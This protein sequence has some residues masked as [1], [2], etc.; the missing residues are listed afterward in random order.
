MHEFPQMS[1]AF[2]AAYQVWQYPEDAIFVD[3]TPTREQVYAQL[4]GKANQLEPNLGVCV[5]LPDVSTAKEG[6]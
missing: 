1:K 5:F 3:F 2:Y 4:Y 6:T